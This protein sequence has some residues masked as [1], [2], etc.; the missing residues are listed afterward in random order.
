MREEYNIDE[1]NP[2]KNPYVNCENIEYLTNLINDAIIDARFVAEKLKPARIASYL[3][4]HGVQLHGNPNTISL[5]CPVGTTLY[6]IDSYERACSYHHEHRNNLYYCVNDYKCRHLC[7][8]LCNDGFDYEIYTIENASAMAILGNAQYFG[9]RVFLDK[10]EA[11]RELEKKRAEE[12]ELMVKRGKELPSSYE[13][14]REYWED[15]CE[16]EDDE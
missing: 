16:D 15:E 2:R 10:E 6:R 14:Y 1:L 11:E 4:Q 13:G 9:T 3:I 7:D 5:P 12:T 8:G